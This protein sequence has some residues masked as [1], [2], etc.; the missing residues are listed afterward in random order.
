MADRFKDNLGYYFRDAVRKYPTKVAL[1]DLSR[2]K[3]REVTYRELDQRHDHFAALMHQL[4]LKPGDRLAMSIGNR[5]E[6]VE[7]MYGAMRAGIVPVPLNTKLGSDTIAFTIENAGCV[8]AVIEPSANPHIAGIVDKAGLK[9]KLA[10][11]P[12]PPGWMHYEHALMGA[13][14]RFDPPKIAPDHPSFQP[15][16]SGSTGRP[17]GV[18]LTHAGQLW[19][20]RALDKYWPAESGYRALAA[21]PLYHKNAM[22]GAVKPMLQCGGSVVILPGFEPRRFLR[23]LSEYRCT[24]AGGVPA[25]F[26]LLLQQKDLIKS[27][28]F[29]NLKSLKIGSAPTPKEL[30]DAVEEAFGI[31]VAESY[32]LTE[33]GP[34]MIGPRLDGKPAPHGSCGVAWPEGEVKLVG[35]DGRVSDNYGELWVKNPGVTPGYYNLPEVNRQRIVD[36][37]LK[38]GDLFAKDAEGFFYFKGRTDDMFNCGGENVYPLEVENLMLKHPAVAD[39]SVVP[40][41]HQIKGE[42]PVALVVKGRNAEVDEAALKAFCLENGPAYAHP[43]RIFFDESLPLNGAGKTDRL[44]VKKRVTELLGGTPLGG[45]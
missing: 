29:S 39:V 13:P 1:I 11:D 14:G 41:P 38:T 7:I 6:F 19:W 28:D 26:T 32:G 24:H 2:E 21:V 10:F 36:G 8:G 17:K 27:L 22:A 35:T 3:P 37:W 30:M 40:V 5:F 25:V 15:Y 23:V 9:V 42:A 33:G 45:S 20:I 44:L 34:V 12:V 16:T 4:G 43:R 18:V 31:P